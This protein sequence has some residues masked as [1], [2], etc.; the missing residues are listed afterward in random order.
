MDPSASSPY[1]RALGERAEALHPELRAYFG[2]LPPDAV[3]VGEGVFSHAGTPRRAL[4]PLLRLFERRGVAFGGWAQDVPFTVR[5]RGVAGRVVAERDFR[6]PTG[7]WTMRDAVSLRAPGRVVDRLGAPETVAA[8]FDVDVVHGAL[9]LRSVA[10]GIRWGRLRLRLP[11]PL[12]PRIRLTESYDAAAVRQ[13]V[14]LTI[15]V[16]VLG[17]IYEYSGTFTYRIEEAA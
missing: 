12:A 3:G 16:P 15:D 2:A 17:R 9:T 4:R 10:V 8:L 14:E 6:L 13:R 7:I 1:L 11:R 5:N